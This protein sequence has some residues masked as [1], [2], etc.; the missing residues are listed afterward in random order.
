MVSP[1]LGLV[2]ITPRWL[3]E[4][5]VHRII[6]GADRSWVQ[7]GVDEFLRAYLTPRGRVAFYAAA[8]QIYL[9]EPHGSSGFWTRLG[10]LEP[11][12]LFVW[13]KHDGLVPIGFA[14][15]VKETLPSARHLELDCGHVPQIERPVE[16]HAAIAAF[17][18]ENA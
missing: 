12:A 3:V 10:E 1:Q 17:L 7:A 16:T 13:G 6:P 8:R 18:R 14:A 4:A 11:P 5:I 9:E 15:H 2:Q